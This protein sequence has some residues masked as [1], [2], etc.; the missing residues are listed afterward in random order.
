MPSVT[1]S[2]PNAFLD[3]FDDEAH[4]AKYAD[5][6][7][8]FMPGFADL[9]RMA[10]VLMRERVP[11]N[12]HILVHGAGGGLELEAF[13]ETNPDWTFVGVDPARAMLD[14]AEARMG[15]HK[16]RA[17]FHH[18]FIDDAPDGP[19][20]AATSLLTLHFLDA[21]ERRQTASEI[22]QRLK[23]GAPC[24]VA[25]CS[26]PQ[27]HPMRETWLDR[28]EAFAV[29]SGVE[30]EMAKAARAAVGDSISLLDPET[31]ARLLTEAGLKDVVSFY[32]AFTWHGWVGYAP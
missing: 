12:A 17:D 1:S 10:A 6:P 7:A 2:G 28:Y 18:G 9:H 20:D 23:P 11:D 26:F 3:M 30:P 5:G 22:V 29:A 31:D 25:H 19:F 14:Q 32:S 16:D 15:P 24:I 13:A 27:A 21:N 4:A 8:R